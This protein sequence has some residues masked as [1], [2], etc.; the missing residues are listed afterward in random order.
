MTASALHT[1]RTTPP[2]TTVPTPLLADASLRKALDDSDNAIVMSN[3]DKLVVY[4]NDGFTRLFGFAPHEVLGKNLS[5]VLT[6]P[7][8]DPGLLDAIRGGVHSTGHFHIE[9]LLYCKSGQPRWASMMIN[10]SDEASGGPGGSITMLTDI[11]LTKMHEVLQKR[12]LEGMVNELPLPDL[13]ALMC[14]E[15][16]RIAPEV[17]ASILSVDDLGQLRPLAA[18]GLSTAI[19]QGLNGLAIG[20]AV[21]SCGTAAFRGE[22][23]LVTDIATDPLWDKYRALYAD[24]G[25]RACWSSPIC[26]HQGKVV[27]T[28]A[29]YYRESRGPDALHRQL[30]DVCLHLCALAI[31]RN[32]TRQRIHQLA[33]FDGLT[34]LPNRV[35]FHSSAE[36]ALASLQQGNHS[37][38]LLFVDLDRFKQVNDT[39]GLAAGDA[40]LSEVAERLTQGLRARDL[41]GRLAADEFVLLLS[42]CDTAQAVQTARRMLEAVAAPMHIQGQSHVCRASIGIAMF[43][44]DGDNID[45]LLRHA[46]QA[47]VQAKSDH[48]HSL[49]LFSAD[50]NRHAQERAAVERALRQALAEDS[51]TLHYQPQVLSRSPGTLHSVEA[52]ARWHHPEWGMIPP[53]RF[54]PV[55]EEAGMIHELTL[56][57]LNEAC[58]QL[59]MWRTSGLRVPCVAVNLSGRSFHQAEFAQEICGALERHGLQARDVLLEITESVMMDALPVTLANIDTLHRKGFKLSLDDFGTGYSSLSYLHRLPISELKLDM[60]FV[61]DLTTSPTARALTI[62]VLSIADSLGMVVV[63][64]GVE[65]TGQ[66]QWLQAHGCPVMQG[67]LFGKPLPPDQL[68]TWLGAQAPTPRQH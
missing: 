55:A 7:R 68:E 60:A 51:L 58:R 45:T 13:M 56:W 33:F 19:C 12:V 2:A 48:Q 59:A 29:F 18:P 54:I 50:M 66:Q 14:H 53:S 49:Q 41:I 28:F 35:M 20:P 10:A 21:G 16:E 32:A 36:R 43:P 64:E 61:Q 47:M 34:G 3:S 17:T 9:T 4:V 65:T 46:D 22:P 38:A 31:E 67:Y 39:Q 6:G 1:S 27:G 30:V 15:V 23:V 52:L 42:E 37:G 62:S 24:S 44:D 63:A 57:L 25:L 5:Q 40:V 26:D 11:T 8:S